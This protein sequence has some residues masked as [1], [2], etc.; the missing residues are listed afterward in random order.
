MEEQNDSGGFKNFISSFGTSDLVG[1]FGACI[2]AAATIVSTYENQTIAVISI[3]ISQVLL[4][5]GWAYSI[6]L[7]HKNINA[8]AQKDK[9]IKALN[10]FLSE[11]NT[12]YERKWAILDNERDKMI[13]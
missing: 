10:E 4:L 11:K 2:G 1:L 6:R 12:E 8:L 3:L 7:R 5:C 13:I 9:E